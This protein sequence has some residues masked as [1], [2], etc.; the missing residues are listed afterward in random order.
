[1]RVEAKLKFILPY[2]EANLLSKV[3]SPENRLVPEGLKVECRASSSG[4]DTTIECILD[5][6]SFVTA[7]DDLLMHIG[8]LRK[9][10]NKLEVDSPKDL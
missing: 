2:E 4:L 9:L 5:L 7:L 8:L 3:L 10:L 1:M 6:G